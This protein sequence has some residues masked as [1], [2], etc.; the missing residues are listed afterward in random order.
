M[1]LNLEKKKIKVNFEGKQYEVTAPSNKL[2]KAFIESK[3]DDMQ[4][5]VKLLSHLGLPEAVC[6]EMDQEG[7]LQ[8]IEALTPKKKS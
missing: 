2:L 3:E 4:K 7:L 8:I 1:E 5:T 6:W